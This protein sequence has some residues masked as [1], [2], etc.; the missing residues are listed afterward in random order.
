LVDKHRGLMHMVRREVQHLDRQVILVAASTT[1]H[2]TCLGYLPLVDPLL[3]LVA[4]ILLDSLVAHHNITLRH[5]HLTLRHAHLTL[6]HAHLCSLERTEAGSHLVLLALLWHHQLLHLQPKL[7]HLLASIGQRQQKCGQRRQKI[8][9]RMEE[10]AGVENVH[11]NKVVQLQGEQLQ[12]ALHP[13][14]QLQDEQHQGEQLQGEQP[15]DEEP[16][17]EVLLD[18]VIL[19]HCLMNG[20]SDSEHIFCYI[21][22]YSSCK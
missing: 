15:Q 22:N 9:N 10:I 17:D 14:A 13:G 6:R 3:V 16:Q 12:D 5:A 11:Q 7:V 21:Y 20:D 18:K 8:E 4:T 2:N 1:A 19:L